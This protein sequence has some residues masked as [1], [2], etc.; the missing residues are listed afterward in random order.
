MDCSIVYWLDILADC[1]RR[2][3]SKTYFEPYA[4]HPRASIKYLASA[5]AVASSYADCVVLSTY[6]ASAA[7]SIQQEMVADRAIWEFFEERHWMSCWESWK[8]GGRS[9][10]VS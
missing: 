2:K 5:L 3:T 4:G 9:S 7:E 8:I 6:Q 10:V 1:F